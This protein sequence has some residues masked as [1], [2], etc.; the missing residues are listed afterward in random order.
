MPWPGA[1]Q[2]EVLLDVCVWV[3]G[4]GVYVL[5]A[6]DLRPPHVSWDGA[7]HRHFGLFDAWSAA[8]VFDGNA[9]NKCKSNCVSR[10]MCCAI[11]LKSLRL[12]ITTTLRAKLQ[13]SVLQ[14]TIL[15]FDY[16][17]Y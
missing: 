2:R 10:K 8:F 16:C 11:A 7:I 12:L 13:Q 5:N 4:R 15:S 1:A 9:A 6:K 17:R 14:E 3:R